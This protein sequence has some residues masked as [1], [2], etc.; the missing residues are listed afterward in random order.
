LRTSLFCV[1]YT[2]HFVLLSLLFN[3]NIL[4]QTTTDTS[5]IL[6]QYRNLRQ[7]CV[8]APMLLDTLK[9][10]SLAIIPNSLY[11]Q[12]YPNKQVVDTSYYKVNYMQASIIWKK[13]VDS[14]S[15]LIT[16]RVF[17]PHLTQDVEHKNTQQII[18]LMERLGG[19][20]HYDVQ[21]P[22][23]AQDIFAVNGLQYSGS[24]GRDLSFGNSQDLVVNANFNLQ[25]SGKLSNDIE[26][27]AAITDNNLP[28]QPEGN[29]QQLQEFD[30]IFIQLKKQQHTLLMGDYDLTR[31]KTYF[32]NVSRRLQGGQF[33]TNF[34]LPNR[35]SLHTTFSGAI[36]KGNYNRMVF[37][38]IEG[39]QGPYK[40]SGANNET[41]I[42][43]LSGSERVYIDGQ[44]LTRGAENDYTIDYNTA[45]ITFMPKQLITK[46]K[47]ITLE[48]EYSDQNY[49]RSL[50]YTQTE[51]KS[52]KLQ[53]KINFFTEQDAKNQGLSNGTLSDAQ[54]AVMQAV[55]DSLRAALVPSIDTVAFSADRILYKQLDTL[56]YTIFQY[57][58]NPDSARYAVSFSVVG[59]NKGNYVL[60][61][62]TVN[63]RIYQFVAPNTQGLPQGNYEPIVQIIT[64]KKRQ[65]LTVATDYNLHKN[66]KISTELA[67]SNR[68][69]NTF[70]DLHDV[71]DKGL[72]A[73][74]SYVGMLP[75][76][77]DSGIKLLT[78][79]KYEWRQALFEPLEAYRPVEFARNWSIN[80]ATPLNVDE[81]LG[82][83]SLQLQLPKWGNINYKLSSFTRTQKQYAGYRHALEANLQ[84]NNWQLQTTISYVQATIDSSKQ[85]SFFRPNFTLSKKFKGL[86]NWTLG[87]RAEQERN[88]LREV[89]SDSLLQQSF[90]YQKWEFFTQSATDAP[91]Q[92]NINFGQRFDYILSD[93]LNNFTL[94]TTANNL[95]ISGQ[96][97]K[98]LKNQWRW[99]VKYRH[100]QRHQYG[101]NE[102]P[103]T[104]SLLANTNYVLVLGKG[105]LRNNIT[106][107]VGS[108]QKQ[109]TEFYYEKV[110]EGTGTYVWNDD[111]DGVEE[112]SEFELATNN[113][114]IDAHYI[115]IILPTNE[116]LQTKLTQLNQVLNINPKALWFDKGGLRQFLARFSLQSTINLKR[117]ALADSTNF[118][119][120][121]PFDISL[122]GGQS[123]D[124]QFII[125]ENTSI[126][127]MLYFN[128]NS[129]KFEVNLQQ[130]HLVNQVFLLNGSDRQQKDEYTAF[131]KYILHKTFS[132]RFK[133]SVGN[134]ANTSSAFSNK[135]YRIKYYLSE[136]SISLTLKQ[137]LRCLA[138]YEYKYALDTLNLETSAIPAQ[139]A[140][141]HQLST[142]FKYGTPIKSSVAAKFSYALIHYNGD[143]SSPAA[144]KLLDGLQP[145]NNYL[146]NITYNTKIHKNIQLSISY[147]GRKSGVNPA[148]HTG[149]A[150]M[151]AIF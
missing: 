113:N 53:C 39:N 122:F 55:G 48:F 116:Y 92:L 65:L 68:D 88:E 97:A 79:A 87:L 54:I 114:L 139:A 10:D 64:P 57:S 43:V 26:V 102:L 148:Q 56:G 11:M 69:N 46:D 108:G 131:M 96:V 60:A 93:S 62:T 136:P 104:Q 103:T 16:Y 107:Q 75:I 47:R 121:I 91:R 21:A 117:E 112:L 78:Q 8:A 80:A 124:P 137:R 38:G 144:Y 27:L 74:L 22:S 40:L 12:T 140:V 66:H 149:R 37:N 3:V 51:Y 45:E 20:Y 134:D 143:A 9:I 106:Y 94:A 150:S 76:N 2:S 120:F 118:S 145:G 86:N 84:R 85:S 6:Q 89:F 18:P 100:L 5:E 129:P 14:D 90:F 49:L 127:N 58:T 132:L 142:D 25:M 36:A 135:N 33:T 125:A 138:S 1:Y 31:P 141:K 82:Q 42:I 110:N 7:Q 4:A 123:V 105:F 23:S 30:R 130:Q 19:L 146:W 29:T 34:K 119:S 32:M 67:F 17:S 95:G 109:R 24:F 50:L 41:F 111:G 101:E 128:R 147:D 59:E 126:R 61:N 71:D 63:G 72:A 81:H 83:A 98:N 52:E 133:N 13:F 77:K 99:Q 70:S 151:R 35:A 73:T 15:L 28:F 44:L 115:R